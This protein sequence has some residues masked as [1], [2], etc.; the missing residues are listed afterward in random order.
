MTGTNTPWGLDSLEKEEQQS[1]KEFEQAQQILN[2]QYAACF[3]TT[4][5]KKV[6]EHLKKITIEQPAWIPSGG[7]ID[8]QSAVHHAFAREGQNSVVRS[9]VDRINTIKNK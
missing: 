2:E 1:Q 8:G 9:I 6:L 5:G 3:K 4:A 7:A